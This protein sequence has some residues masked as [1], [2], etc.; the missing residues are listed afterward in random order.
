MRSKRRSAAAT[1]RCGSCRPSR[2]AEVY[3][4]TRKIGPLIL[5]VEGES[6]GDVLRMLGE[7][8]DD[9][10]TRHANDETTTKEIS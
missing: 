8:V 6:L 10:T 7:L 2:M 4:K 9:N 3:R 1:D 5:P